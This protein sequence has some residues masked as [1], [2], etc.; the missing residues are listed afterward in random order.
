MK[1]LMLLAAGAVLCAISFAGCTPAQQVD[2]AALAASAKTKVTKA[3]GV[4]QPALLD[5]TAMIPSD[6]NLALLAQDNGKLCAAVASLDPTN[7]QSLVDSVIP[8]ALAVVS[9]L[10]LDTAS[11]GAIRV[12]LAAA[13]LALSN[14]LTANGSAAS[15]VAAAASASG[16]VAASSS[17]VAE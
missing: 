5:L 8:Q 9:L 16:A 4:V 7:V 13:Q 12:A 2:V 15:T 6:P 3:C 14:W 10:P 17:A 11:Q 1:K